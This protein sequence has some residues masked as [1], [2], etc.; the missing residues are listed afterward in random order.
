MSP[1][2]RYVVVYAETNG[3]I[4]RNYELPVENDGVDRQAFIRWLLDVLP[5][6]AERMQGTRVELWQEPWPDV[7]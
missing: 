6:M 5:S 4:R 7:R 1:S 3:T 2:S